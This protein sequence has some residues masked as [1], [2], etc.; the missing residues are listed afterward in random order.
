LLTAAFLQCYQ[1]PDVQG[2]SFVGQADGFEM[3]MHTVIVLWRKITT[4]LLNS[5]ALN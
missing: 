2:S 5:K 1:L 3:L 4:Y